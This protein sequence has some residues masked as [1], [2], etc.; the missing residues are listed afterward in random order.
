MNAY[1]DIILQLTWMMLFI[2]IVTIPAMMIFAKYNTLA[3][4]GLGLQV[5]TVG[6]MGGASFACG[7]AP[8]GTPGATLAL[9]CPA[10]LLST[11]ATIGATTDGA[12]AYGAG[13]IPD[14]S[15]VTNYCTIDAMTSGEPTLTDTINTCQGALNSDSI[16]AYVSRACDGKSSCGLQFNTDAEGLIPS[17]FSTLGMPDACFG[18]ASMIFVSAGCVLTPEEL[19]TRQVEGLVIGCIFISVALFT[20][21]YIDYIRQIAKNN[22][23]EW[24]VK[25]VTAGDY[26]IEFDI[27]KEF[28][29]KFIEEHGHEKDVTTTMIVHFRKWL[30]KGV[31]DRLSQMPDLGFEDEP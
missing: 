6:N 31:E 28:Y 16:N 1:F 26:S 13:I 8:L 21:V 18:E 5:Y 2:T 14:G 17:Y 4:Y 20:L 12:L 10:G 25:T 9:S 29:A 30:T 3:A 15:L 24:D 27:S 7:Q 23:V 11:T 22:F 19:T